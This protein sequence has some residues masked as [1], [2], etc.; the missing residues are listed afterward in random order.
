MRIDPKKINDK[1]S[2]E[3]IEVLSINSVGEVVGY[4]ITDGTDIGLILKFSNGCTAWFF[5]NE[6]NPIDA[7]LSKEIDI[8]R[9]LN[10]KDTNLKLKKDITFLLNPVNFINWIIHALSDVI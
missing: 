6:I 2:N 3:L 10:Q 8:N 4:K 7:G 9:S 1:V 5:R